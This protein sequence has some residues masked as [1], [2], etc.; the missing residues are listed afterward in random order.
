MEILAGARSSG[1]LAG[2]Q[3]LMMSFRLL[4]L[5]GIADYESAAD[6]FRTCR[7]GGE[8]I[9][10]LSDC[11]VSIPVIRAEAELLHNDADFNA[12]ARHSDLRIYR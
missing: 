12:I 7:A 4:T 5:E 1:E 10:Q 9:S 2:L 3:S 6:L 11:L 8:T